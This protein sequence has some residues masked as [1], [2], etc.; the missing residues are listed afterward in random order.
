MKINILGVLID[1]ITSK[2]VL[3]KIE[4]FLNSDTQHYITTPN[5]EFV[6]RAQKDEEF[7]NILNKSDI[8]I[9]DGIGLVF[10]SHFL[11]NPIP[12]RVAGSDLV[13]KIAKLAEYKNCSLYLLGGKEGVAEEAARKLKEKYPNLKIKGAE[14][15]GEVEERKLKTQNEEMVKRINERQPDILLV[16]FGAPKQEKWIYYNLS[17]LSSVKVAI[18]VGGTFDFIAGRI[19]RAPMFL[20]K[21]GMEW[22]WRLFIEPKRINRILT[23]TVRFGWKVLKWKIKKAKGPF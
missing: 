17:K 6:M 10:A 19:K 2:E 12:E 3:K 21:L 20:R 13:W 7:R 22:L 14:S 4:E 5:P 11:G 18:G 1:R 8:A 23:A 16:A 15:G 9:P